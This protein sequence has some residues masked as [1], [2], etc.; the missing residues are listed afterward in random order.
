VNAKGPA[1]AAEN[2]ANTD[3]AIHTS[4]CPLSHIPSW[5]SAQ[6]LKQRGNFTFYLHV[7]SD[8]SCRSPCSGTALRCSRTL[9]AV[10]RGRSQDGHTAVLQAF[11]LPS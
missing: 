6:L 4:T 7:A 9:T 2:P 8:L 10:H 11:Q 3:T 5:C 1:K